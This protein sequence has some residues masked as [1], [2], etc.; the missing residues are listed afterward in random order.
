LNFREVYDANGD[1]EKLA[2]KLKGNGVQS[3]ERALE[4]MKL[5]PV[6]KAFE[7]MFDDESIE[8]F[9][10][11]S[12]LLKKESEN[13]NPTDLLVKK[14][15]KYLNSVKKHYD[16]KIET[17]NI[18]NEINVEYASIEKLNGILEAEF[19]IIT[20]S[21]NQL[22]H[23]L[24]FSKDN[25]YKENSIL[26]LLWLTISQM[27]DLFDAE[28][29]INQSNYFDKLLLDTPVKNILL[30]VG[31]GEFEI[32]RVFLLLNILIRYEDKI[33]IDFE[34]TDQLKT[35]NSEYLP[36]AK[37]RVQL[38]TLK[39]IL[40]D[41]DVKLFIGVNEFEGKTFYSKENFEELISW[42]ITIYILNYVNGYENKNML[43]NDD[44]EIS[45]TILKANQYYSAVKKVS[46]SSGY[47]FEKL[48]EGIDTP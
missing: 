9:I 6:H 34:K 4:E 44:S 42:L 35:V 33:K 2:R 22:H 23:I 28:S 27:K 30:K 46:E 25:N 11:S 19:P 40:N 14:F 18:L 17:K 16:L 45:T 39:E 26:F 31:K 38:F 15:G 3:I 7:Q 21:N 8:N 29:G 5:E 36:I 1:Y 12:V 41:N 13:N 47:L 48:L 24:V 37:D 10:K 32:F 43:N 20:N